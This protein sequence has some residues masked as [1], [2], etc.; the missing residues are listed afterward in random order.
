MASRLDI[1]GGNQRLLN[2][3]DT[4]AIGTLI[5]TLYLK[6]P[7]LEDYALETVHVGAEQEDSLQF[8]HDDLK[9]LED[10]KVKALFLVNPGNPSAVALHPDTIAMI[11]DFVTNK[12]PDL[13]ILTD[14]VYGTFV[15]DFESLLG[16]L[17]RNTIGV[18]S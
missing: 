17:P 6:M 13:M 9:A 12:R 3:G 7:E 1:Q 2:A 10:P 4:I 11:V 15:K 8:T 5:F 16:H 18:Y 14:D